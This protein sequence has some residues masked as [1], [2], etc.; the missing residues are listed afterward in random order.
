MFNFVVAPTHLFLDGILQFKKMQE[1]V[2]MALVL[3][4]KHQL[5]EGEVVRYFANVWS[6]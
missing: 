2:W 5:D 3:G 1:T 4:F 6:W